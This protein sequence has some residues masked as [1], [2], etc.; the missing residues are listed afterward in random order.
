V[1]WQQELLE[2]VKAREAAE[3]AAEQA[4]E[5]LYA[6]MHEVFVREGVSYR[7]IADAVGL[8]RIRVGQVLRIQREKVR[9]A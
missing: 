6:A 9:A 3:A 1:T 8:S 4:Q 2:K 7:Q 5:D